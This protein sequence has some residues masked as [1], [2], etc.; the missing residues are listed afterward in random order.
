M[1]Q[2][3]RVGVVFVCVTAAGSTLVG[4]EPLSRVSNRVGTEPISRVART[5]F[6]LQRVQPWA[7][8]RLGQASSSR[9]SLKNGAVIGAIAGGVA[10][11]LLGAVG[12][13]AGDALDPTGGESDECG[14]PVI[15]GGAV[16]A[17]LGSLIGVGIDAMFERAPYS[18]AGL[19]GRRKGVRVSWRF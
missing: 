19:A 2:T 12:C 1:K 11:A 6:S 5:A 7:V 16:G 3:C 17:G 14:G 10:G 8:E 9:D 15:L 13:G 18:G 4:A